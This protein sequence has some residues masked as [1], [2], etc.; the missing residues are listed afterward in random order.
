MPLIHISLGEEHLISASFSRQLMIL[1]GDN[2]VFW[3]IDGK[4]K[5]SRTGEIHIWIRSE[6]NGIYQLV[7]VRPDWQLVIDGNPF[8]PSFYENIALNNHMIT[9][10][11]NQYRFVFET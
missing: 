11:Y 1:K 8:E 6:L 5:G 7:F 2:D 10:F 3:Q 4:T 9:L